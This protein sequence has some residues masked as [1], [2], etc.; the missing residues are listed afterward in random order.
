MKKSRISFNI[1]SWHKAGL[2]E[3]V[4]N[5]MGAGTVAVSDETT[6]IRELFNTGEDD[7]QEIIVFNLEDVDKLP[8]LIKSV[9]NDEEKQKRIS[10]NAKKRIFENYTWDCMTE[11]MIKIIEDNK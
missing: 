3:R 8:M 2:T 6:R 7:T 1:M 11:R 10:S 4:I 5:I 9:L